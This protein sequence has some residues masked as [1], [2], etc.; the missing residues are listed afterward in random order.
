MSETFDGVKFLAAQTIKTKQN[1]TKQNMK[2]CSKKGVVLLS[3][4][5]PMVSTTLVIL[6]LWVTNI[7]V[8]RYSLTQDDKCLGSFTGKYKNESCDGLARNNYACDSENGMCVEVGVGRGIYITSDCDEKCT[9][10]PGSVSYECNGR[11]TCIKQLNNSGKFSNSECGSGCYTCTENNTCSP[12]A[13]NGAG[14]HQNNNCDNACGVKDTYYCDGAGTCQKSV[15]GSGN[16]NTDSCGNGCYKC[17]NKKC[18]PVEKNSK[19][20]TYHTSSCTSTSSSSS[21][22]GC[23]TALYSCVQGVCT[24]VES[25]GQFETAECGNGCYECDKDNEIQCIESPANSTTGTHST[26]TNACHCSPGKYITSTQICMPC[27]A[28]SFSTLIDSTQCTPCAP[29]SAQSKT[30][31]TSCVACTY[32]TFSPHAG[33]TNCTPCRTCPV[34][35]QKTADCTATTDTQCSMPPSFDFPC[36]NNKV[37]TSTIKWKD[38]K[39]KSHNITIGNFRWVVSR[40]GDKDNTYTRIFTYTPNIPLDTGMHEYAATINMTSMDGVNYTAIFQTTLTK[41]Q[42][43]A[44]YTTGQTTPDYT[45]TGNMTVDI[46]CNQLDACTAQITC[47]QF[48]W[49]QPISFTEQITFLLTLL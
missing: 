8:P 47:N 17:S 36:W 39:N 4:L 30:G 10:S 16:F 5:I 26:C 41:V 48:K 29:G 19:E 38:S 1:K 40:G 33:M 34:G 44:L 43:D 13:Q 22:N 37:A 46:T 3:V 20:G 42:I 18:I 9:P 35:T 25:G 24:R 31:Q 15:D 49:T 27:S 12:V 23:E 14:T 21:S 6:G 11:G 28:G 7:L 45:W 32:N 2:T